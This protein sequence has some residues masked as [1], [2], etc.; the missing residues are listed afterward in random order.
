MLQTS[1]QIVS[2]QALS[3]KMGARYVI[4]RAGSSSPAGWF[5]SSQKRQTLRRGLITQLRYNFHKHTQGHQH[6]DMQLVKTHILTTK[7]HGVTTL[8]HRGHIHLIRHTSRT[9][10]TQHYGTHTLTTIEGQLI[11][12]TISNSEHILNTDTPTRVPH[13]TLQQ[14][15]N[16]IQPHDL[17][18]NTRTKLRSPSHNHNNQHTPNTTKQTNIPE[19][20]ESI[21]DDSLQTRRLLSLTKHQHIY[22]LQTPSPQT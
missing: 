3:T 16:I 20:S 11:S 7:R 22:T 9:Y 21:L 2:T 5:C 19:L 17:A 4:W 6:T 18:H 8:Q 10:Q 13:T 15:H 12:D 1:S 14:F